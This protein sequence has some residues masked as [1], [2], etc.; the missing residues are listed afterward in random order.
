MNCPKCGKQNMEEAKFC[1]N[2]G[3]KLILATQEKREPEISEE[4]KIVESQI[5]EVE[6]RVLAKISTKSNRKFK[7]A[8]AI[9]VIL[10]LVIGFFFTGIG[11]NLKERVGSQV[12]HWQKS[13][14]VKKETEE[15]EQRMASYK[16]FNVG[17]KEFLKYPSDWTVIDEGLK[18]AG[19]REFGIQKDEEVRLIIEVR[20]QTGGGLITDLGEIK[21]EITNYSDIT[22]ISEKEDNRGFSLEF[23]AKYNPVNPFDFSMQER[24]QLGHFL[25]QITKIDTNIYLM[26]MGF[27]L[28]EKWS[29]YQEN[30]NDIISSI[31]T[32]PE[33]ISQIVIRAADKSRIAKIT[34]SSVLAVT[35]GYSGYYGLYG[36]PEKIADGQKMTAWCE[37]KDGDGVGEW[38]KIDF[39]EP[40]IVDNIEFY[41]GEFENS[42]LYYE[43]NRPKRFEVEFS[44]QTHVIIDTGYDT[45][46]NINLVELPLTKTT[47]LKLTIKE[48][49]K[50]TVHDDTCIYDIDFRH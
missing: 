14:E 45:P 32:S 36:A 20:E 29:Q 31:N 18:Q 41:P 7:I 2:C 50:G 22:I 37:G 13:R 5:K 48:V 9:I 46:V 40:V 30:I 12:E 33:M 38:I 17:E 19:G 11:R 10:V 1:K 23:T 47:Y 39:K 3:Q 49:N 34:A 42:E 24:T 15:K 16:T 28:Q 27:V 4:Q 25:L 21:K 44:D 6:E 35:S 26:V 8:V 43:N